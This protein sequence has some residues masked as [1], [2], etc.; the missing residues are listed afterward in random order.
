MMDFLV[1]QGLDAAIYVAAVAVVGAVVGYGL[2]RF[3]ADDEKLR[4]ALERLGVALVM[5]GVDAL[6]RRRK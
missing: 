6:K 2:K 3:K 4:E 5:A 1:D